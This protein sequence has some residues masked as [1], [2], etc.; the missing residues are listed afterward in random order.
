MTAGAGTDP[1][2][3]PFGW[4]P[5]LG[6]AWRWR[7]V[8]LLV[9]LDVVLA[10]RYLFWLL[11]PGRSA[12]ALLYVLL[13]G[14]E[15]FNMMQGGGFWWTVWGVGPQRLRRP[16]PP[17]A[18]GVDVPVDVFIPV[19]NEP[20]DI[21]EATIAAAGRLRGEPRV[22]VLDDG[23]NPEIEAAAHRHGARYI[24]RPDNDGA[25]AGNINWSLER[26]DAPFVAVLDCDHVPD[27]RFLE[28]TLPYFDD[29]QV[30]FVQTPQ[31]YANADEGGVA[32]ASSSQQ[33]LFF[34]IIAVGR[35]AHGA[36][37]CCGT[38]MVLRRSALEA[39][40]G[41]PTDSL[42]EDFE[43][44]VRLHEAGWKSR[45]VPEV[46]AAGLGPEDM[47]S[48]TTQQLR[49]ARGCLSALP[50]ILRARL[51]LKV[52]LNYL[53]SAAYWLTGW[54]LLVYMSF[55]VVRILTGAQP[56]DV[57]SA[58]VFLLYWAPYFLCSM[59]TVAIAAGGDYTFRAFALLSSNY[60][61]HIV[62]SVLTLLRRKGRFSVTPKQGAQGRQIRPVAVTL[63][64]CAVLV[65]V[66]VYGLTRDQS[67]AT[68]NN[69]AFAL[70]HVSILMSGAWPALRPDS[71][72]AAQ[73]EPTPVGLGPA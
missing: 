37:F 28:T 14:A 65:S 44:S 3:R 18:E 21:V 19:Y 41:F 57:P 43:L 27:P 11:Q 53:M 7:V 31:Y 34:G 48:Y 51:P 33:E 36:M 29:E 13:I 49:W 25:K 38:N 42:T 58:D 2:L 59:A 60:W 72:E 63:A 17:S 9:L 26:T 1:R 66:A 52:R 39:T 6:G 64:T 22:A 55:P 54:T 4:N 5:D 10:A 70:M 46:L 32:A 40:G 16:P 69:A 30:A 8:R 62:A 23:G 56:I 71:P 67:P 12:N 61:V 47:A 73:A 20:V 45:Y 68:V 15:G 24:C 35:D 50:R